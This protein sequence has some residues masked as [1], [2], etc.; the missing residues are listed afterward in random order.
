MERPVKLQLC[1]R[2]RAHGLWSSAHWAPRK[3]AHLSSRITTA[4]ISYS[5]STA[6][7]GSQW[8][9][10]V[11][12]RQVL[13][14]HH[15][16]MALPRAISWA[17]ISAVQRP[18]VTMATFRWA[19]ERIEAHRPAMAAGQPHIVHVDAR[20]GAEV[21]HRADAGDH[22]HLVPAKMGNQPGAMP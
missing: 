11:F 14:Y 1:Q 2:Q 13:A 21:L 3:T 10:F 6:L 15:P 22:L 18:S 17:A 20:P 19:A 16:A 9:R 5:S 12:H 8:I 4:F 7:T